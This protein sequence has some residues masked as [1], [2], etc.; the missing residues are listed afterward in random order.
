MNKLKLFLA[1][2]LTF[3]I[4]TG[5]SMTTSADEHTT[6][7]MKVNSMSVIKENVEEVA[8]PEIEIK[9][10]EREKVEE[11]VPEAPFYIKINRQANCVT[12]Y[13]QDENGEFTIPIKAMTC[14]VGLGGIDEDGDSNDTPLGIFK[15]YQRYVWRPLFGDV[16]GQY[17]IRF[18][19]HILFH[20]VPYLK[21][22]KGTLKPGEYNKLGQPASLGCVRLSVN[23]I[24]WLYDNCKNGTIVEVY[25][26][27]NPGPLGKPLT[28][29]VDENSSFA[30]WDPTDPDEKNPWI[31]HIPHFENVKDVIIKKGSNV[32]LLGDVKGIDYDG[33]NLEVKIEN[34]IDTSTCGTYTLIYSTTG[35]CGITIFEE[36]T[37]TVV[38]KIEE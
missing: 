30:G 10:V 4:I 1:A 8:D 35:S 14:S 38:E 25:D 29:K 28:M 2:T 16:E 24:K 37:V 26:D 17:A 23:D 3:S 31:G 22:D 36:A 15:I 7:V 32:S 33:S 12:I 18:N 6:E 19:G 34:K 20:S 9:F 11:I 21:Q 5:C 13:Q 27:E